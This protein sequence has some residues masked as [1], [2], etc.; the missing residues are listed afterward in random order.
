MSMARL[1][2]KT[3]RTSMRDRSMFCSI[4]HFDSGLHNQCV[5][6]SI[7]AMTLSLSFPIRSFPRVGQLAFSARRHIPAW[8][9][10]RLS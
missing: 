3:R 5:L 4:R 7:R 1:D 10:A 8:L 2:Q 6:S 9:V